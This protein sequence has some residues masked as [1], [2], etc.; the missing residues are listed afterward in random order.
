[1]ALLVKGEISKKWD[2][3]FVERA[4]AWLKSITEVRFYTVLVK[5]GV[6]LEFFCLFLLYYDL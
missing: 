6:I 2:E 1:M 5:Y 3:K 4:S